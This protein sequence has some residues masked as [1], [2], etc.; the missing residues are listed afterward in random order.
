MGNGNNQP[1]SLAWFVPADAKFPQGS[2]AYLATYC[3]FAAVHM[4]QQPDDQTFHTRS[5]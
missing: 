3:S 1:D 2:V 4:C 5:P